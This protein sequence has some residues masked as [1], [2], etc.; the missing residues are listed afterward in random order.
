MSAAAGASPAQ[1][2]EAAD[3]RARARDE[4]DERK[5]EGVLRGA[6]RTCEELDRR[7]GIEVRLDIFPTIVHLALTIA[8]ASYMWLD[9]EQV[10]KDA[11]RK[12]QARRLGETV[13]DDS[14][15]EL[16]ANDGLSRTVVEVGDDA[17]SEKRLREK[18]AWLALDVR[19]V[20]DPSIAIPEPTRTG[21]YTSS[22][23]PR[24]Y[25]RR[26]CVHALSIA[27]G[28]IP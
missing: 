10:E 21:S 5:A 27:V 20:P 16:D 25:A 4:F 17:T 24:S 19:C 3:Y 13:S 15:L 28:T 8:Q 23:H 18:E 11:R 6:R 26:S 22:T 9:P 1:L 12:Q 7:V 2:V 14:D